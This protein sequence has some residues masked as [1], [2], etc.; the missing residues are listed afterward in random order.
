MLTHRTRLL[1][2]G[3]ILTVA[4]GATLL[5]QTPEATRSIDEVMESPSKLEGKEIAIRG[6]VL[7]Y[8]I[9][10]FNSTFI[11]HGEDSQ[12]LVDFSQ[13]SV[14]NGLDNNRTVYAEGVLVYSD[15][16]WIF[17]AEVIKTSCPSKYEEAE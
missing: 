17:E 10:E 5:L 13:A 7:D 15:G 14:S 2:I 6:E 12:L 11:I 8:S 3:G 4:L 1:L 16:I 9:D